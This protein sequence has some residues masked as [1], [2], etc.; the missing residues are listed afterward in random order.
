MSVQNPD[1]FQCRHFYVTWDA[2]APRGCRYFGFKTPLL[3]A[4]VVRSSSGQPC[5][6]FEPRPAPQKSAPSPRGQRGDR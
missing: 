3:P 2:T 5:Q 6:A 1:C 4:Q